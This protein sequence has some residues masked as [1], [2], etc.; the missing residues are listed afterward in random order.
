MA[1]DYMSRT[2]TSRFIMLVVE[3][4]V[5][6]RYRRPHQEVSE[7]TGRVG[8]QRPE[9]QERLHWTA[10]TLPKIEITHMTDRLYH[11]TEMHI[12]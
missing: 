1:L 12:W 4:N 3:N 9:C 11:V 5:R 8:H 7:G 2:T 6:V 10:P